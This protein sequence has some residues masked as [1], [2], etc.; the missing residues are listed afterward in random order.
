MGSIQANARC[1]HFQVDAMLPN[2]RY[3]IIIQPSPLGVD[4]RASTIEGSNASD[5]IPENVDQRDCFWMKYDDEKP[6]PVFEIQA[7]YVPQ[8]NM[9]WVPSL[10]VAICPLRLW[11][12]VDYILMVIGMIIQSVF[13]YQ[14]DVSKNLTAT[15]HA[16]DKLKYLTRGEV[17]TWMTYIEKLYIHPVQFDIE[18]NIKSDDPDHGEDIDSSL[19]LHSIAQTTNSGMLKE[20]TRFHIWHKLKILSC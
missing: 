8:N 4:R 20:E 13:K 18:L 3:P 10:N 14:G 9:T 17:N 6:I 15:S 1:R 5:L 16:N 19:T 11:I 2:A 12:D 7:E